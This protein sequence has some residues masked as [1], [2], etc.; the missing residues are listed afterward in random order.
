MA[1]A[2][3]PYAT[4]CVD[5]E[6]RFTVTREGV[7][8]L[9]NYKMVDVSLERSCQLYIFIIYTVIV[10]LLVVV[11]IIGNS[12]TLVVFWKGKFN[13]ST[14]FL[15][16]CLSLTDSSVLLSTVWMPLV[17][18]EKSARSTQYF[19]TVHPYVVVYVLPLCLVAQTATV[20]VT[21]VVTIN[22]YIVVCL[23]LRASQWCTITKVKIQMTVVLLFAILYN[24]PKCAEF[25]VVQVA[26][27]N[28]TSFTTR[29]VI[30]KLWTN[31]TYQ[32]LYNSVLYAICII[33]LPTCILAVLTI[34]LIKALKA[35]RRM[36]MEMQTLHSQNENSMTFVL[37]IIVIVLIVCQLPA[38]VTRMLWIAAPYE[39]YCCGGY[40]FYMLP[41]T[42]MLV[43]LN[44]AIN[45][46][47]YTLFNKCFRDVL[48]EKV[49][50]R[51][52]AEQVV[53]FDANAGAAV[54]S[55]RLGCDERST[56]G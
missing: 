15:F 17:P 3:F 9:V 5:S 16:M 11:G 23:P 30:T 29:Y 18:F 39:A 25:R 34:R 43:V 8:L 13:K 4:H 38:L 26:Y 21:V 24:I 41:I 47:I 28:G 52:A 49:F 42:N 56:R 48:V 7:T 40:M 35:H 12:L 36:Q 6:C 37:V 19:S 54:T 51:H 55:A 33:V 10:G 50:K 22:R 20:W 32:L 14:S 27:D 45:F 2:I 44:S 46:V 1:N 53:V 31:Y